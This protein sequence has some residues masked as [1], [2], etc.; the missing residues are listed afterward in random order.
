VV[1]KHTPPEGRNINFYVRID[2]NHPRLLELQRLGKKPPTHF[3]PHQWEFFRI[4]EGSLTVEIDGVAHD[5]IASDGEYALRPG[6]H[7]R[8]TCL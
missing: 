8:S 6:P 7:H 3:H 1:S 4:E 5:F 2:P